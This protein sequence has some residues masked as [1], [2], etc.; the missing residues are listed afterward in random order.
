MKGVDN[1][2]QRIRLDNAS[3]LGYCSA[4]FFEQYSAVLANIQT[5][6]S[7]VVMRF[8]TTLVQVAMCL[9]SWSSVT[10]AWPDS[11]PDADNALRIRQ[12]DKESTAKEEA[13][14]TKP[15]ASKTSQD[16]KETG[17]DEDK[18]NKDENK[19][20]KDSKT[21]TG[22]TSRT[23]SRPATR[24]KFAND[25]VPGGITM[26]TPDALMTPTP[27]YRIKDEITFNWNYTNLRAKPTAVDVI[28][29]CSAARDTW[30]LTANMSF[31]TNASY[32]WDSKVQATDVNQPL[33]IELYTLIIKDSD[34]DITAAPEP[35]YLAQYSGLTFG[36]YQPAKATPWNEW[37]CTGC[38]AAPSLFERP[39]LGLAITM[40][41]IS[42]FS[43]TWFVT[44]LGL[45]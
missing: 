8:D 3:C 42:L 35:G 15:P 1:S 45:H 23:S 2:S 20:E 6:L 18:D 14:I 11:I 25:V 30:V 27:L 19:D 38:S 5:T 39:A 36:L 16:P 40:S 41:L 28:L 9:A 4:S 22:K 43:F 17:K 26:V 7:T 29:S 13:S 24:T 10:A 44:G 12:D 34:A 21:S 31:Q 33:P 37:Q 32:V